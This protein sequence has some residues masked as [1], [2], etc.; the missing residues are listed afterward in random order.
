LFESRAAVT[1][2]TLV[3]LGILLLRSSPTAVASPVGV[4]VGDA[5]GVAVTVTVAVAAGLGVAVAE[6]VAAEVV[7]G[8][9]VGSP[10]GA[11]IAA[12]R[13]QHC[14]HTQNDELFTHVLMLVAL[15]DVWA[16]FDQERIRHAVQQG[17]QS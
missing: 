2:V 15:T 12:R 5:V 7:A 17:H 1:V 6:G 10:V 3:M 8:L 13:R 11:L 16:T 14:S 4:A 9:C